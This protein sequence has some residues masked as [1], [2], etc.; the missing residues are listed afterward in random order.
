MPEVHD[1]VILDVYTAGKFPD[2]LLV[3]EFFVGI[4]KV[5]KP[6]GSVAINSGYGADEKTVLNHMSSVFGNDKIRVFLDEN[7]VKE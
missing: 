5:L 7:A 3:K 6:S 2:N 4:K 1:F